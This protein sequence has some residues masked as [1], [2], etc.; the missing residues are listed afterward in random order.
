[1]GMG[2]FHTV[3]VTEAGIASFGSNSH[4]QLGLGHTRSVAQPVAV[5]Q[6]AAGQV[7]SVACGEEHTL[8]LCR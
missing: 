7:C 1:M 3:A 5:P 4:G 2:R 8:L 6:F